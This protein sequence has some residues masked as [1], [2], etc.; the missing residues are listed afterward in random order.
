MSKVT[1]LFDENISHAIAE[2]INVIENLR[3]EIEI[4]STTKIARLGRGAKDEQIVEFATSLDHDCY[5]VTNDK[6]FTKRQLMPFI[7]A[8]KN[9]GLFLIRFPKGSNFW[10]KYKFMVNHWEGIMEKVNSFQ[11]PI[12]FSVYF[13]N[14]FKKI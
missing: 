10:R 7:M 13:K 6:D 11:N 14:K 8:S 4:M 9:T 1:F 3:G 5:I 12:A 2:S